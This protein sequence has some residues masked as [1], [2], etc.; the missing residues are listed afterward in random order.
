M[1]KA[2]ADA[3]KRRAEAASIIDELETAVRPPG[4]ALF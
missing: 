4:G 3:R 1:A 2:E